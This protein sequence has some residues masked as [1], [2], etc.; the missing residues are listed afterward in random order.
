MRQ[1]KALAERDL[2][3]GDTL[4]PEFGALGQLIGRV[5]SLA[6]LTIVV[7]IFFMTYKPLM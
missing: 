1:A 2:E 3:A 6:G 4:S 7:T 5:G